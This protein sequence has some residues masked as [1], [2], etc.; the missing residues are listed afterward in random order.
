[1]TG[2]SPSEEVPEEPETTEAPEQFIS[3]TQVSADSGAVSRS[4]I[5]SSSHSDMTDIPES[6]QRVESPV[7]REGSRSPASTDASE[8]V[9]DNVINNSASRPLS[10]IAPKLVASKQ[11]QRNLASEPYPRILKKEIRMG[12]PTPA[13]KTV[14]PIISRQN[15]ITAKSTPNSS[16]ASSPLALPVP[17][18]EPRARSESRPQSIQPARAVKKPGETRN[19]Q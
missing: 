11:I 2:N 7:S 9:D 12:Q 17:A 3:P 19:S 8:K 10:P 4:E 5:N 15:T 1:M 6:I 13:E 16:T 14:R 18:A